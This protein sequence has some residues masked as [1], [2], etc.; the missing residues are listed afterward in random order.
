[1]LPIST[2]H[3]TIKISNKVHK[4]VYYTVYFFSVTKFYQTAIKYTVV[5]QESSFP[6]KEMEAIL[7]SFQF[8]KSVVHRVLLRP[9][10]YIS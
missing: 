2:N 7:L 9:F 10:L 3:K 5:L 6:F 4:N 1:M 8:K